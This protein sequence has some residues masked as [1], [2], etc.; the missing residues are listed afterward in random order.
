M[1]AIHIKCGPSMPETWRSGGGRLAEPAPWLA[2]FCLEADGL[3]GAGR[4]EPLSR[5]IDFDLVQ[6]HRSTL[7]R[8][9]RPP[10]VAIIAHTQ[11]FTTRRCQ[12]SRHVGI[13]GEPRLFEQSVAVQPPAPQPSDVSLLQPHRDHRTH[14]PA[15][16]AVANRSLQRCAVA[17]SGKACG[18]S[19]V[20]SLGGL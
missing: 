18:S 11:L 17:A 20:C 15:P 16:D 19:A 6:P 5:L 8:L 9:S 1:Q 4:E 10:A 14:S 3:R 7:P 2:S 13:C 12:G